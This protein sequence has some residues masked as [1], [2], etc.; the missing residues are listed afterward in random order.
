MRNIR[1][2]LVLLL[3]FGAIPNAFAAGK[4]PPCYSTL[5]ACPDRGCAKEDSASALSN[6]RKHNLEP[7][8][9]A[10]PLDFADFAKLQDKVESQFQGHYSTLVKPD[11]VWLSH[12]T[13]N[14]KPIGEGDLVEIVGYIAKLPPKSKPHANSSG[15]SVN[16]RLHGS[17]NNDFHINI[18]RNPGGTE[19]HGV[20]VEMIPQQRND[21]WTTA[22]L[23]AAQKANRMVRVRG[24]L[25]F[26]NHHKVNGD[27]DHNLGNQPKR[28]SLWEVHPVT[29]FDVCTK[30]QCTI[31]GD[32]WKP[33]AEWQG[34]N[35]P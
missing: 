11:R 19:F 24:Q 26:D 25:F 4:K 31:D 32:G 33:L 3:A 5:A 29:A 12:M 9:E 18:T 13:L 16:C 30:P 20:V 34:G 10:I 2:G 23:R 21:N 17:A 14:G 1:L 8:G 7:T 22:R 6:I 27:P 28:M 35:T 15:E